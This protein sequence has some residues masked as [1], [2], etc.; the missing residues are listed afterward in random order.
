MQQGG[1]G[2]REETDWRRGSGPQQ[3]IKVIFVGGLGV[4]AVLEAKDWQATRCASI[5]R[6]SSCRR[7]P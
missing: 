5:Q 4:T 3:E 2:D 1:A 7:A 6:T